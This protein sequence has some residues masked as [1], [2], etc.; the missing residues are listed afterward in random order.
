MPQ[1]I[2]TQILS[3][4]YANRINLCSV[5]ELSAKLNLQELRTRITDKRKSVKI[6]IIDDNEFAALNNLLR[7]GYDIRHIKDIESFDDIEKYQIILCDLNG[8]GASLN[9]DL[10]GA[11]VIQQIKS[12]YPE[13]FVVAYTAGANKE[14]MMHGLINADRYAAKDARVEE[15]CS[16]LDDAI[17]DLVDPE[18]VWKKLRHR[19][20]DQD[21]SVYDLAVLEDSFVRSFDK[22]PDAYQT[23]LPT[24]AAKLNLSSSVRTVIESFV[25]NT[26]FYLLLAS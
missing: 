20:L 3:S 19:L 14:L 24:I 12:I 11:H 23:T 25:A 1:A 5:N 9:P 26:L 17:I 16:M 8:V 22:K 2:L 7:H 21:M 18:K 4:F 15:W 13:K 10:Q 6:V